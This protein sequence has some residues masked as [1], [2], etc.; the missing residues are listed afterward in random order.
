MGTTLGLND[1]KWHGI[2][3][4][5][6][7]G[8]IF[9]LVWISFSRPLIDSVGT[10]GTFLICLFSGILI[11]HYLQSWYESYQMRDPDLLAKYGSYENFIANSK[12]DFGF[13]WRGILISWLVPLVLVLTGI[14]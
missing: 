3:A 13:F 5:V 1:D 11:S 14:I 12:K 10:A 2:L 7:T 4:A 6:I 8:I 9:I